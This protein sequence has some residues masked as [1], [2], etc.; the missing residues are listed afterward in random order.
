MV[1]AGGRG[2]RARGSTLKQFQDFGGRPLVEW[3]LDALAF[4]GCDPLVL[5]VPPESLDEIGSALGHRCMVVAGGDSRQQSVRN[6]LQ[7]V[8]SDYVVVHDAARPFVTSEMIERTL[9]SL[10]DA[11]GAIVATPLD[12]TLKRVAGDVVDETVSRAH[13]WRVQT[14]QSFR[15][16]ALREAHDK[17]AAEGVE[18]TDDASLVER[19]G[20]RVVVVHSTRANMKLTYPEDFVIAE[21]MLETRKK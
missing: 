1:A 10:D 14:P 11:E 21:A 8:T 6:G 17:A 5:V 2:E 3:S 9:S 4:S 19:N 12:E 16:E 15:T 13:L 18:V 7:H 20:G